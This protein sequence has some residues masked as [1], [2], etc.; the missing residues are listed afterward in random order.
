MNKLLYLLGTVLCTVMVV[1]FCLLIWRTIIPDD[2]IS[3][4]P[5]YAMLTAADEVVTASYPIDKCR[6][7]RFFYDDYTTGSKRTIFLNAYPDVCVVNSNEYRIELTANQTIH[8][9]ID[10]R[11]LDE[12][13]HIDMQME[14]YNRVHEEDDSYDYDH[15]LYV[16]CTA[17]KMT[18]YAPLGSFWSDTRLKLD[19][20][21]PY[22]ERA[23]LIFS[24]EGV[25]A[26]IHDIDC[27]AMYFSTSGDSEVK[28]SGIVAG[29]AEIAIWGNSHLDATELQTGSQD[30]RVSSQLFGDSYIRYDDGIVT[31]GV[32]VGSI[33]T[34][35]IVMFLVIWLALD[36]VCIKRLFFP[37][38]E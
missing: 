31:E 13:L 18:I 16:D 8:D 29:P 24:H 21:M 9:M 3:I 28:L 23:S 11:V 4:D 10:I 6:G 12:Q 32:G 1:G 33:F 17:F 27:W 37:P 14:C 7:A 2:E 15:G 25:E 5:E 30:F 19:M 34:A 26:N 35:M 20:G 38:K 36:F 22:A